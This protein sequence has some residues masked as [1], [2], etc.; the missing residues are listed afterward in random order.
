MKSSSALFAPD[1]QAGGNGGGGDTGV[2]ANIE[3]VR[4]EAAEAERTRISSING[5][6]EKFSEVASVKDL[7]GTA[8]SSGMTVDAFRSKML[9]VLASSKAPA[10]PGPTGPSLSIGRTQAEKQIGALSLV[11]AAKADGSISRRMS[12]GGDQGNRMAIAMGFDS[13]ASMRAAHREAIGSGMVSYRMLDIARACALGGL[14]KIGQFG[15][16]RSD[17]EMLSAIPGHGQGDFPLLLSAL[18]NKV[19]QAGYA[20]AVTTWQEWAAEGSVSDF[21]DANLLRMSEMGNLNLLRD[22]DNVKYGSFN[23]RQESVGLATYGRGFSL[24]RKMIYNDDLGAFV[25]IPRLWGVAAQRVPETLAYG[26]LTANAAMSDGEALFHAK[27]NNLP[28]GA[29]LSM[30]ALDGAATVMRVQQGFGTDGTKANLFIEPKFLLVPT[31]LAGTARSLY[32]SEKDPTSAEANSSRPNIVRGLAKPISSPILYRA[33]QTAWYLVGDP[34][35]APVVKVL[36]LN[37]QKTPT[38]TQVGDGSILNTKWEIIFDCAAK[39]VNHEGA[40]KGN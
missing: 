13:I 32:E 30:A 20:E 3:K 6:A 29:A 26:V 7:A 22:G 25:E 5:L 27:H 33:S 17:D 10:A 23:E 15:S 21:K 16:F 14:S 31:N 9:D 11:L 1:A 19:M 34:M 24:S 39:S 28:S 40:V 35:Q 12:E 38:I 36:F 4:A 8:V 37:G 18:A 2:L